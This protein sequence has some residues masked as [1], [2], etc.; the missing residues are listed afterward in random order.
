MGISLTDNIHRIDGRQQRSENRIQKRR[1]AT[2]STPL[3][4]MEKLP[5]Y[6]LND[7]Q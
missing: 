4:D 3:K 1:T 2:S 7:P 6:A 5:G